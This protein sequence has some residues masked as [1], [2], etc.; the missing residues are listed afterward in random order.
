MISLL[1]KQKKSSATFESVFSVTDKNS[2]SETPD[3]SVAFQQNEPLSID[4][5]IDN[6]I[7]QCNDLPE[8]CTTFVEQLRELQNRLSYGKLHLAILGQFNRGKSTFINALIGFKLLPTSILPITSVPTFISYGNV[9]SCTIRFLNNN[10]DLVITS[11]AEAINETLTKY[12]AEENNPK[13][14]L[15]VKDV[16]VSCPSE[17]LENGTVLIDTPGFGSTYIHNTQSALN[18]L[19]E[20]DAAVFLVSADPPMT[21]T[22]IEFLKQVN[23]YVPRIFFVLNKTDLLDVSEVKRIEEFIRNILVKQLNYPSDNPFFSICALNGEKALK[24]DKNDEC[25][26]KSGMEKIREEIFDFLTREKYFTLSQALNDK[27]KDALGKICSCLQKEIDDYKIPLEQLTS[28]EQELK[29]QFNSINE[30]VNSNLSSVNSEKESLLRFMNEQTLSEKETTIQH[31]N[32]IFNSLLVNISGNKESVANITNALNRIIN[33]TLSN[34][35]MMFI[36]KINNPIRKVIQSQHQEFDRIFTTCSKL[37]PNSKFHDAELNEKMEKI[38]IQAE[39]SWKPVDMLSELNF[40][41]SWKDF[42]RSRKSRI[43]RL[44]KHF[45]EKTITIVDKNT[46]SLNK[47]LENEIISTFE[48]INI[49][50]SEQYNKLLNALDET[51]K[52]KESE[53]SERIDKNTKPI[54]KLQKSITAIS[55]IKKLIV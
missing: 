34:S 30:L 31:I 49:T 23:R 21:Q 48:K 41:S 32:E 27:I 20:C 15:C 17:L 26:V 4:Q 43:I 45:D 37:I 9:L 52:K 50:L 39:Q 24:Q 11:S 51:S 2:Q 53:I 12:A 42:F 18:V 28:E 8:S 7:N 16:E 13:N 40:K 55:D 6:A 46:E 47:H 35:L 3:I 1:M 22:E 54:E 36:N 10:P 14:V 5:I 19:V 38:E 33:E 44:Q 25:W 29:S